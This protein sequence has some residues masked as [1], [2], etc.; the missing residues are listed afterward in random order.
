MATKLNKT[1]DKIAQQYFH[2]SD[3]DKKQF[4]ETA[5]KDYSFD[6]IAD[7]CGTYKNKIIRDAKKLGIK[8]KSKSE[9]QKQALNSGRLKP[10]MQGKH[11]NL[12][13][14]NRISKSMVKFFKYAD[15]SEYVKR[16]QQQWDSKTKA[17]QQ[18][19]IK[20]GRQAIRVAAKKGSKLENFLYTK[21]VDSMDEFGHIEYHKEHIIFGSKMHL[22]IL[23]PS[24]NTVIEVDGISHKERV[25][26][27]ET[28]TASQKADTKKNGILLGQGY[29]LI[30][31]EYP[32]NVTMYSKNT[33]WDKL[34]ATLQ[35][36]KTKFPP[37]GQRLIR[38][39]LDD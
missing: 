23:L 25:W 39:N 19:F 7:A 17:E 38:I 6:N 24:M 28:F 14:K 1:L 18:E 11:H 3:T 26:G 20:K 31:L 36:I 27:N 2:L 33:L 5:Y 29:V 32:K 10:P 8:I 37:F 34:Y 15:K 16:G 13:T 12:T 22:D 9:A 21:L 30:R 35:Q 4:I